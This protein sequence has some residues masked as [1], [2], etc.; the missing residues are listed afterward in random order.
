MEYRVIEKIRQEINE[1]IDKRNKLL[2]K[3]KLIQSGKLN[4]N[5]LAAIKKELEV[6]EN[7][8]L[9]NDTPINLYNMTMEIPK[10]MQQI[11]DNNISL[12][13]D[14]INL[15]VYL[16]SIRIKPSNGKD[17]SKYFKPGFQEV[18]DFTDKNVFGKFYSNIENPIDHTTFIRK[19]A[20]DNFE[21]THNILLPHKGTMENISKIISEYIQI[22][23]LCGYEDAINY[24]YN[25]FD[26]VKTNDD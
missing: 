15:Y 3:Q 24:L 4:M 23:I 1:K 16:Y 20:C 26:I 22:L 12:I 11:I 14:P 2:G 6:P 9:I 17:I 21:Q 25:F 13:K 19:S 5:H 7:I 18:I 8:E 10:S